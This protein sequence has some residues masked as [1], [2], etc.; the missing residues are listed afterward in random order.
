M[1]ALEMAAIIQSPTLASS[2]RRQAL[3]LC[4]AASA[5]TC[6]SCTFTWR[7]QLHLPAPCSGLLPV[8]VP[9]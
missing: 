7:N 8:L 3:P 6:C 1:D 2:H 4:L 5:T 9:S